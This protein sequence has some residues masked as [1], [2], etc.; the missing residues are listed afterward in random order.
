MILKNN[1]NIMVGYIVWWFSI[2]M[3]VNT[4]A[5]LCDIVFNIVCYTI[6][7]TKKT[8]PLTYYFSFALGLSKEQ[9]NYE[10]SEIVKYGQVSLLIYNTSLM[11]IISS[12]TNG[13]VFV[14]LQNY[15]TTSHR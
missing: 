9:I 5:N 11:E 8:K 4:T 12:D 14:S 3:Y 7:V 10:L 2:A 6:R 13:S 1:K 15:L